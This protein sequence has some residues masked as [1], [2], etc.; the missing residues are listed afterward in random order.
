[1]QQYRFNNNNNTD[2]FDAYRYALN[3]LQLL[4]VRQDSLLGLL[5]ISG[6][7]G[8]RGQVYVIG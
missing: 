5:V 1:M 8:D 4:G 3:V 7:L 2:E 6:S